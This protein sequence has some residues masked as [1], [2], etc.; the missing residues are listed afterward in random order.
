MSASAPS[1]S[2]RRAGLSD[3]DFDQLI[4]RLGPFE[5]RPKLAIAVSG[6]PDSLALTLLAARWARQRDGSLIGLT[7]DHRLR[8]ESSEEAA[9][10]GRWLA[11]LGIG[12]E[13]LAWTGDK[14]RTGL[15]A[16]ARDARYRLLGDF[17]RRAGVLHLLLAHHQ[18]DQAETIRIRSAS[19]SGPGG[20]A[21]MPAVAERNGFRILRPLLRVPKD[22][23]IATLRAAGRPW[24]DDPS[25]RS[26]DFARGRLRANRTL[27]GP[28]PGPLGRR[29]AALD[30]VIATW[31][32][33]RARP[34]PLGFVDL[35]RHAFAEAEEELAVDLLR[36]VLLTVG[37]NRYPPATSSLRHL[38]GRLRDG[39]HGTLAGVLVRPA[40]GRLR[41]IREA[42]AIGG[43]AVPL[44]ERT[45][46]DQR[47]RI[48]CRRPAAPL[49]VG[50]LGERG[51]LE[52]RRLAAVRPARRVERLVAESLPAL[53]RDSVLV[54]VP[55][56]GLALPGA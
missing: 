34:D 36:R 32:A 2:D 45:W 56:L 54:A 43:A 28:L 44:L 35:D 10:V 31:L 6:G 19:G 49:V 1:A 39:R 16:A 41:F 25:N 26:L 7:V 29:R 14:P 33:R 53:F 13:V 30:K 12:H 27:D 52:R 24:L 51:W 21:G 37:G 4:G 46:F 11:G 38:F 23:L 5:A 9:T 48:S 3:P 40:P 47:F 8:P 17:C 15:Q 18:D 20:L 22:R 42:A 55:H 50:A